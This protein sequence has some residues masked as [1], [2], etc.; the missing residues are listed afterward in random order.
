MDHA[1][2][3]DICHLF[4]S[5]NFENREDYNLL[6]CKTCCNLALKEEAL[7]LQLINTHMFKLNS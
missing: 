4:E 5:Y 3:I 1:N 7:R 2:Q 6:F